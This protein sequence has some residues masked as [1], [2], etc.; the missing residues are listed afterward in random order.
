MRALDIPDIDTKFIE[1]HY[2]VVRQ[3]LD[4]SLPDTHIHDEFTGT[5]IVAFCQRFGLRYD[6]GQVRFRWL[7]NNLCKH[8]FGLEDLSAPVDQLSNINPPV[9]QVIITENKTNFLSFPSGQNALILFGQGYAIDLIAKLPWLQD[10]QIF[11]WG[12]I[13]THGFH[14]L[15]RLRN[16]LP[17]VNSLLMGKETLLKFRKFRGKEK[18][19][20]RFTHPLS[21]LTHEEKKL[22]QA[23]IDNEYAENLRLEQERIPLGW[24]KQS[25]P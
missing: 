13:D 24:L 14:I 6:Q 17:Q 11:Y 22:Y 25:F 16:K 7:D 2:A 4:S 15:D 3:L 21:Y 12:D 9:K 8:T 18:P 20:K 23:L 19:E 5:D 10:K 1:G